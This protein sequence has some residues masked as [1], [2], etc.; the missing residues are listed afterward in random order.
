[1]DG[2]SRVCEICGVR[3]RHRPGFFGNFP[4]DEQRCRTW[5]K[6]VGKEDLLHIPIEK[7]RQVR[8]VCGDHFKAKDFNKK[9][10]R[11]KKRAYPKLEL[12]AQPLTEHQ[13]KD[14]PQHVASKAPTTMDDST[15]TPAIASSSKLQN[16]EATTQI[17]MTSSPIPME[18]VPA[19]PVLAACSTTPA[20]VKGYKVSWPQPPIASEFRQAG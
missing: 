17:T 11:L 13:L 19:A 16:P 10:N 18:A 20:L 1:M 5:V 6:I 2:K 7:L 8:F 14:F 15:K 4:I 9:G 12:S 3:E